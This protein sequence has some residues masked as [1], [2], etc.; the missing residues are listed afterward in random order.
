MSNLSIKIKELLRVAKN[1]PFYTQK[2]DA[3]AITDHFLDSCSDAE[4]FS[5]FYSI[6][7]I[8][9]KDIRNAPHQLLTTTQNIV[10]RGTTSGTTGEA[11]V[12]FRDNIWNDKRWASLNKFLAW[13]GID[14]RV[15]IA[16]INSRLFPL[17]H[18]DYAL[19]GGIDNQFLQWLNFITQK[20]LALRGY[21]S[22]LCEVALIA[23]ERINFSQVKVI[24]CTGEPLFD[25]QK[26]LLRDIFRC[27]I[28]TEYGSQECGIYGFSCP[29]CGNLH[30]DEGRCLIEEKNNRLLVTDLYSY[31]M[32]M[33]R[34]YNGD[35]VDIEENNSCPQG[36][37]NVKILGRD[38]DNFGSNK[39]MYSIRGVDYYRSISTKDNQKL[40]GYLNNAN[41][42]EVDT[43]FSREVNKI[44]SG[45]SGLLIQKFISPID[46]Y[47]ATMPPMQDKFFSDFTPLDIFNYFQFFLDVVKGDRWIYYNT[48]DIILDECYRLLDNHNYSL[49]KQVQLDKLYLLLILS[50]QKKHVPHH[51][52][53][54]LFYKYYRNNQLSLIYLDLLAI[55]LFTNNHQLLKLLPEKRLPFK[56]IIDTFDY[57]L[58]LRLVSLGIEQVRQK[59]VSYAINKLNPLLPLFISDLDFCPLYGIDCLPSVIAHWATILGCYGGDDYKDNLPSQLKEREDFLWEKSKISITVNNL[60]NLTILDLK[61]LLIKAV[62]SDYKIDPDVFL[63][64]MQTQQSKVEKQEL[65]K[66]I[67][68]IP[69]LNYF[70]QL[71]LEKGDRE[72]AYHCLLM[73]ENISSN[74]NKFNSVSRLYNFKQKIF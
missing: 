35:L 69:F 26:Q 66:N 16:N 33:I 60:S 59:K 38:G 11:F 46:L 19:I 67:A 55:S 64:A 15:S 44:F 58:I 7:P 47:K 18:Q 54:K 36:R 72:K 9:K 68:F 27:P 22:R 49:D 32:P 53:E 45:D 29:V 52:L 23:Q 31:T 30:I 43:L 1:V 8:T 74:N 14:E 51:E 34:Y 39:L 21:P 20:P 12:F 5:A 28:I 25:H 4:L 13:W 42:A 48:P 57:Q 62:V 41:F 3:L 61:E 17:R 50:S 10:Y 70:A 56:I 24:I 65:T 6:P 73:S 2:L 37:I 71:F 63:N 40:V